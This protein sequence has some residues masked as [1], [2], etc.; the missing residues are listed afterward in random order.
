[1]KFFKKFIL[2]VSISFSA[3][4]I[5]SFIF[6][7]EQPNNDF[8][9]FAK[10]DTSDNLIGYAWSE[11]IG[12]VS[13]NCMNRHQFCANDLSVM[14][15]T[16]SDCVTAGVGGVCANECSNSNYGVNVAA[17]GSFSGYAWSPNVGWISFD[18]AGPYPQL[19]DTSVRY[20]SGTGQVTGWAKI[21]GL[22]D[23]GWMKMSGSWTDGVSMNNYI[24]HGWS[25]N[26][27]NDGS[28]M[29]WLSYNCEDNGAGG[30]NAGSTYQVFMNQI[31]TVSNLGTIDSIYCDSNGIK[32]DVIEPLLRWSFNDDNSQDT[33]LAYELILSA[34]SDYSSPLIS[35]GKVI[36]SASAQYQVDTSD[37]LNYNTLYYWEVRV[38]DNHN[39]ASDWAQSSF[40][41][42]KHAYPDVVTASW[43]PAEPSALA[44]V[45]FAA[46]AKTY[47]NNA[48]PSNAWTIYSND[49]NPYSVSS[50]TESS[51]DLGGGVIQSD[52]S[53]VGP[54]QFQSGGVGV[55]AKQVT[56]QVSDTDGYT[57]AKVFDVD[58]IISRPLW[59]EVQ[60]R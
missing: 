60:P 23:N 16:D 50:S 6:V 33:Q 1:M 57:C 38:W 42:G 4:I 48:V 45:F 15:D 14:C 39:F 27:G 21:I 32:K 41:T 19:P 8:T 20:D 25:W 49:T 18:P 10:A 47:N 59:Q 34:N 54:M 36:N 58:A 51:L 37:G 9:K 12:W 28:G 22:N 55:N 17:D 52:T 56:V 31:P 3:M 13:F 29:G 5:A 26:E 53:N 44:D 30:C 2:F 40:T 43:D 7:A 24:F 11:N 35:T 46:E